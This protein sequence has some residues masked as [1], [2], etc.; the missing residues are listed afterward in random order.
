M[1]NQ[2]SEAHVNTY[3]NMGYLLMQQK[4]SKLLN[5]V[6]RKSMTGKAAKVAEQV[7]AATTR[8]K[9][10]RHSDVEYNNIP[11]SGRWV[12]P[13]YR[14]TADMIDD[15]DKM[16]SIVEFSPLYMQTQMNAIG[17]D[18]D[19][20]I[21]NMGFGTCYTGEN[22]T[23]T[24]AWSSTYEVASGSQGLTIEKLRAAR[25]LMMLADWDDSNDPACLVVGASQEDELFGLTQVTSSDFNGARPVLVNG[26]LQSILGF[27][28]IRVSNDVLPIAGSTRQCMMFAKSGLVLNEFIPMKTTMDRLPQ[29]HNNT[30]VLSSAT[31]GA[32]R[33]ELGKVIKIHCLES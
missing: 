27:E 25:K 22:G 17:R 32:T 6:T 21:L 5:K 3:N 24:E 31:I 18:Y 4:G 30:Q 28:I 29:K 10:S 11:H 12:H 15:E 26:K 8:E 19:S 7:G 13:K 14:Y 23:G 1:S 20:E 2:F 16:K 9:T 33:T